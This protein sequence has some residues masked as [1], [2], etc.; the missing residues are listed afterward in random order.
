MCQQD[1]TSSISLQATSTGGNRQLVTQTHTQSSVWCPSARTSVSFSKKVLCACIHFCTS[2]ELCSN[3]LQKWQLV[4]HHH[5]LLFILL[6]SALIQMVESLHSTLAIVMFQLKW[7]LW[8]PLL[9][10][11]EQTSSHRQSA[12]CGRFCPFFLSTHLH[13]RPKPSKSNWK[14]ASTHFDCR[15]HYPGRS[16][17]SSRLIPSTD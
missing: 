7:T 1:S 6:F 15:H 2:V 9:L 14:C 12:H 16:I 13:H 10:K 11:S 3:C 4:Y 8:L 17:D 5:H